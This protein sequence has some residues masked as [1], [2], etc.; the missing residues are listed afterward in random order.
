MT[1]TEK[2]FY[3]ELL[4]GIDDRPREYMLYLTV[5]ECSEL[6][7]ASIKLARAMNKWTPKP[8]LK[9]REEL[10]EEIADVLI[11]MKLVCTQYHFE[12]SEVDEVIKHKEECLYKRWVENNYEEK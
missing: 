3:R 1:K 10:I 11:C 4:A 9:C 6:A 7:Q 2:P 5:E 12:Q 8:L